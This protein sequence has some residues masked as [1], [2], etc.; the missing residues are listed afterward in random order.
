MIETYDRIGEDSGINISCQRRCLTVNNSNWDAVIS[1]VN[2][3]IIFIDEENTIIRTQEFAQKIHETGNYYVLVTRENLP[4]LPY[5]VEEIYGIHTSGRYAGLRQTY[6]SFYRLYSLDIPDN[7]ESS[8]VVVVE[9]SNSGYEFFSAVTGDS[10][11]CISAKGKARILSVLQNYIGHNVLV[12]ADGAAFGAGIGEL[13]LY[14]RRHPEITLYL[15][16]SFEWIILSS[17][18][19]DGNRIRDITDHPEEYIES[20]DFFSWERFFTHILIHETESSYMQ[21]SKKR[22]NPVYLDSK[23]RSAIF[24]VMKVLKKQLPFISQQ[25]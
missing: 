13:Y 23:H 7:K 9:D 18:I 16:E 2:D 24:D 5:S 1:S 11:K 25:M 6:N 22:L 14:L 4:N 8:D 15:P 17:G 19:I 10:V 20:A 12:I 3:C 21:Y